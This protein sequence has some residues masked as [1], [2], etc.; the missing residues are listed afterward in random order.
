MESTY[1]LMASN[2]LSLPLQR[3][4]AIGFNRDNDISPVAAPTSV[5][6][7]S[8]KPTA[9]DAAQAEAHSSGQ[10]FQ[11]QMGRRSAPSGFN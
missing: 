11:T 1:S 8:P 9:N 3:G 6:S 10:S 2:G 7:Q 5:H 4:P